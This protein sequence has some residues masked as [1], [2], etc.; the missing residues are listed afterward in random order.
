MSVV[1]VGKGPRLLLAGGVLSA[2]LALQPLV[3]DRERQ[4]QAQAPSTLSLA[5]LESSIA[6]RPADDRLRAAAVERL[7]AAGSFARARELLEPL[8]GRGGIDAQLLRVELDRAEL[9]ASAVAQREPARSRLRRDVRQIQRARLSPLQAERL[10]QVC[11]ETELAPEAAL[12]LDEL[13]RRPLPDFERH[14]TRADRAYLAAAQPELSAALHADWSER[15]GGSAGLAH[16]L[17]ALERMQ[18]A[19]SARA[20]LALF[21]HLRPRWPSDPAWLEAGLALA[22]ASDPRIAYELALALVRV[23]PWQTE[24]HRR[25]M[26]SALWLGEGLRALDE[27]LWLARHDGRRADIDRAL[28]LA[29]AQWD[30]RAVRELRQLT[31]LRR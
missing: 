21:Q 22:E 1:V 16:A 5:Y 19:R 26:R 29:R 8:L 6:W 10:A 17:L 12:I 2:L 11:T 15:L 3:R 24:H 31:R 28:E 4:A 30:L 7:L 18:A 9:F 25:L 20:A 23:Q 13:A 14:V 27:A